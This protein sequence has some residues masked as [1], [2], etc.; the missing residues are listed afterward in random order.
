MVAS[1][2]VAPTPAS[3]SRQVVKRTPGSEDT[4]FLRVKTSKTGKSIVVPIH[5]DLREW[6]ETRTHGVGKAP[7]FPALAGKS[8]SGK[9][10]ISMQF[11]RLIRNVPEFRGGFFA[12]VRARVG[13]PPA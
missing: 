10:G 3:L 8:G 12:L 5:P 4:W 9:S 11:K 2:I 6:L 7:V 13:R 1:R